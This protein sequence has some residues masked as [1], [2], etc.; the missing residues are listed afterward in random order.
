MKQAMSNF[1]NICQKLEEFK[2][3]L[4]NS[5]KTFKEIALELQSIIFHF[6]EIEPKV[7]E[8]NRV[9]DTFLTSIGNTSNKV[10]LN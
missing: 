7:S 5:R 9:V 4:E 1:R 3:N 2:R 10:K 6:S 8:N